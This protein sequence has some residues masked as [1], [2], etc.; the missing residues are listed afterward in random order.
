M[1][2]PVCQCLNDFPTL[3]KLEHADCIYVTVA[4]LAWTPGAAIPAT[5]FA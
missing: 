2:P 1:A 4:I 3:D 5:A